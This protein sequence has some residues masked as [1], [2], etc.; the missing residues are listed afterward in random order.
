MPRALEL[1]PL[2]V[3]A[4]IGALVLW[5]WGYIFEKDQTP[6]A[7]RRD[8]AAG[9]GLGAVVQLGVRLAGVS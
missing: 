9:A 6:G 4:A 2:L 7:H 3:A 8:L 1:K 5:S